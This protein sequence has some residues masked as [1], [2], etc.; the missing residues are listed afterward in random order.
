MLKAYHGEWNKDNSPRLTDHS[1]EELYSLVDQLAAARPVSSS[2]G[3]ASGHHAWIIVSDRRFNLEVYFGEDTR[4]DGVVDFVLYGPYSPGERCDIYDG[5]GLHG[6]MTAPCLK[7][8]LSLLDRGRSPVDYVRRVSPGGVRRD[9]LAP[10]QAVR[11]PRSSPGQPN[12][13][14]HQPERAR[15]SQVFSAARAARTRPAAAGAPA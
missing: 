3:G 15:S 6:E 2:R 7:E 13:P 8:L 5:R 11:G 12:P 4:R 9:G 14:V 10:N 1:L